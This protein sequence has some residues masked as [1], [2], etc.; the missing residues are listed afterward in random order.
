MRASGRDFGTP[1]TLISHIRNSSEYTTDVV[2]PPSQVLTD[3]AD[4]T[5]ANVVWVTPTGA[6]SDHAKTTNGTGPAWV[7]SVVNAIGQSPY[8]T[9]TAIL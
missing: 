4:G 2:A 1:L 6:A 3:I 8:W 5:L 9:N 7:A